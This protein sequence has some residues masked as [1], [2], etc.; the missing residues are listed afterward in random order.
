[1]YLRELVLHRIQVA[2]VTWKV[3]LLTLILPL[4]QWDS[5]RATGIDIIHFCNFL[6]SN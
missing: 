2:T 1:M 5:K 4:R 3:G 6:H